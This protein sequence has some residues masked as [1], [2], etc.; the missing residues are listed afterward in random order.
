MTTDPPT[1]S[2]LGMGTSLRSGSS[3][4]STIELCHLRV[5][6]SPQ[7]NSEAEV[8][9]QSVK[10]SLCRHEDLSSSPETTLKQDAGVLIYTLVLGSRHKRN[11]GAHKSHTYKNS[12][13]LVMERPSPS[14]T[15]TRAL[16]RPLSQMLPL[17]TSF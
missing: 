17:Q 2:R 7:G 10:C 15:S 3:N 9:A 4:P 14:D 11:P 13:D 8:M 12:S 6:L 5:T 16:C 1:Q